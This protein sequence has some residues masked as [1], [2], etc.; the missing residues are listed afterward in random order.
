MCD[1]IQEG[2]N[3]KMLDKDKKEVEEAVA[4]DSDFVE[5]EDD[6]PSRNGGRRRRIGEEDRE[7]GRGRRPFARKK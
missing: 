1:F 3:E 2:L 5:D 4:D 7:G 6:R